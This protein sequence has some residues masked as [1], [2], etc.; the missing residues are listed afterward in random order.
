VLGPALPAWPADLDAALWT[1]G[2]IVPLV[3]P[4]TARELIDALAYAKLKLDEAG[5]RTLLAA[6][7]P[8]NVGRHQ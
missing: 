1:S 5:I 4:D 3:S 2:R 6:Y 8:F 7:L